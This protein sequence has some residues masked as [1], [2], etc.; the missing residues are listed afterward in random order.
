MTDTTATIR[1]K[2]LDSTGV[3]EALARSYSNTLG[4]HHVAIV[5]YKVDAV[6]TDAD[7]HRKVQLALTQVEPVIDGNLNGTLVE[8]VRD[9]QRALWRNRAQEEGQLPLEGGDEPEPT[10]E[11]VLASGRALIEHDEDG[12]PELWD[13]NTGQPDESDEQP[14]EA[15]EDEVP[16]TDEPAAFHDP[17]TGSGVALP[18]A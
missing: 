10:V 6:I 4:S 1:S 2:G 15:S 8:H 18:L 9:I 17:F 12:E 7:G 14:D 3:T 5:E 13:G 11:G 16:D